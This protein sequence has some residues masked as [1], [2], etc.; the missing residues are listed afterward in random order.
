MPRHEVHADEGFVKSNPLVRHRTSSAYTAGLP[1]LLDS[2]GVRLHACADEA[3]LYVLCRMWNLCQQMPSLE[4]RCI[5]NVSPADV[6]KPVQHRRRMARHETLPS[7][8]WSTMAQ[9]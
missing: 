1:E 5:H 9:C 4:M 6:R 2:H 8:P 3:E 7:I